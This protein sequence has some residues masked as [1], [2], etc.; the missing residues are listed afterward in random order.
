M[1]IA[2]LG[3]FLVVAA[4][5]GPVSMWMRV[6]VNEELPE[7]SQVPLWSRDYRRVEEIY[8]QQHP[9]SVI[10]EVSRYGRYLAMT[11]IGVMILLGLTAKR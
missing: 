9:D 7:D 5:I 4:V 3:C 2:L 10:P 8:S 1:A 6:R 11:M